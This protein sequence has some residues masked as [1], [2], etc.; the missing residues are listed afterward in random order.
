MPIKNTF[1]IISQRY[2]YSEKDIYLG[3]CTGSP[4]SPSLTKKFFFDFLVF[5]GFVLSGF[6]KPIPSPIA[7]AA[8]IISNVVISKPFLLFFTANISS[9]SEFCKGKSL[10][11]KFGLFPGIIY[12]FLPTAILSLM[13]V[14]ASCFVA[15]CLPTVIWISL[16][17]YLFTMATEIQINTDSKIA[18]SMLWMMP[19]KYWLPVEGK[20]DFKIFVKWLSWFLIYSSSIWSA[21]HFNNSFENASRILSAW[22]LYSSSLAGL[23]QLSWNAFISSSF[24]SLPFFFL[25]SSMWDTFSNL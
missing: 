25:N 15:S 22:A 18:A 2:L 19:W 4:V 23:Q 16:I 3:K 10:F 13:G 11:S 6:I 14:I 5:F 24:G 12:A 17:L 1:A 20:T 21:T 8:S 7:I 9:Y